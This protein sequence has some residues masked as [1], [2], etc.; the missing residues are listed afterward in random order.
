MMIFKFFSVADVFSEKRERE[1]KK[2][3]KSD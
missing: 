1:K 2:R 3:G